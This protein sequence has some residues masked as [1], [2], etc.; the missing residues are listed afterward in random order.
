[1]RLVPLAHALQLSRPRR[2]GR[3]ERFQ[4]LGERGINAA[5]GRPAG[6]LEARV[7]ALRRGRSDARHKLESAK[8]GDAVLRVVRP[9]QQRQQILDVRSF[10]KL[11]AAVLDVR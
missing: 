1:M 4:E 8:S 7:G 11:E 10:Q 2:L 5:K 9:A 3:G 6:D